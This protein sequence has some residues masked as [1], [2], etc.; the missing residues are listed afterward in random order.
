[1]ACKYKR[2][3]PSGHEWPELTCPISC[4]RK[5]KDGDMIPWTFAK[6]LR[7]LSPHEGIYPIMFNENSVCPYCPEKE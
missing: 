1:M 4:V 5:F 2:T 3:V 6:V 7:G